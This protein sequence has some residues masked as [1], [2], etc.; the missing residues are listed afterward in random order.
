LIADVGLRP[1][2]LRDNDQIG[3]VDALL[4]LWFTLA[5]QRGKGR[6]LAFKMLT[7]EGTA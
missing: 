2:W 3:T 1:V 6:H 7:R 5:V 4:A